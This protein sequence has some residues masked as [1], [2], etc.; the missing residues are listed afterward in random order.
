MGGAL[1]EGAGVET[2]K[3]EAERSGGG[4]CSSAGMSS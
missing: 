3:P 2:S 4:A 1:G